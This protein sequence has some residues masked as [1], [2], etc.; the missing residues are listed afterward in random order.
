MSAGAVQST[1]ESSCIGLQVGTVKSVQAALVLPEESSAEFG[2]IVTY[3]Q[4]P[5]GFFQEIQ[6]G[7][8]ASCPYNAEGC[9]NNGSR[10]DMGTTLQVTYPNPP[11]NDARDLTDGISGEYVL[12][13][14]GKHTQTLRYTQIHPCVG[15]C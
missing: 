10:C 11:S 5:S 9:V 13:Y 7:K 4:I 3:T 15:R 2:G 14:N 6:P 12:G 8:E 1:R